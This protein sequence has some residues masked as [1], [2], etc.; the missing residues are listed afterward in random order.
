MI[1]YRYTF[2][3]FYN[4]AYLMHDIEKL[5][6]V[7]QLI[8][9]VTSQFS[10]CPLIW[11][12]HSRSSNNRINQ[13]HERALRLVYKDY[14]SSFDDLLTKAK[15]LT[16]HHRNIHHLAIE[17]FKVK[18]GDAVS[19]VKDLFTERTVS[20]NLRNASEFHIPSVQKVK[21]RT[22]SLS[23]LGPK[24]WQIVPQILKD[25]TSIESFK[26]DIKD[27]IPKDCP[28]KICCEY[29]QGVGYI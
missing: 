11:M 4:T 1:R 7:Q 6:G 24:I 13:L 18:N 20:Y 14:I 8:F 29:I 28:C 15:T 19:S 9:L 27:W 21:S 12:L 17:M 26:N 22:C 25:A 16:I 23:Y 2:A 3:L 5:P 10:Y